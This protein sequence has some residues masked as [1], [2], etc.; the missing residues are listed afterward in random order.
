L[1]TATESSESNK[2][3]TNSSTR[4]EDHSASQRELLSETQS[5]GR[6][7]C[8]TELLSLAASE[9]ESGLTGKVKPVRRL[10]VNERHDKPS[11]STFDPVLKPTGGRS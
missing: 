4:S 8:A 3:E 1:L 11:P 7:A 9:S 2:S 6:S 5:E 10:K